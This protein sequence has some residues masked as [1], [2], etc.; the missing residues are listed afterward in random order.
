MFLKTLEIVSTILVI[1]VGTTV[2]IAIIRSAI[3][4]F[5][6]PKE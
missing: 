3:S 2:G 5:L 4:Y 6:P 1:L